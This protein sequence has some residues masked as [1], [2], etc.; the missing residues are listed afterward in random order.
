M[1]KVE[2][3]L[4]CGRTQR[5]QSGSENLNL[6]I[7]KSDFLGQVFLDKTVLKYKDNHYT[8]HFIGKHAEP[9]FHKEMKNYT[10]QIEQGYAIIRST[11]LYFCDYFTVICWKKRS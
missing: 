5:R 10:I 1:W 3:K 2:E 4:L 6:L 8:F 7:L 11:L 9:L